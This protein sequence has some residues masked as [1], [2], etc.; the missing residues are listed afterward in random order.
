VRQ[1]LLRVGCR[2]CQAG[3]VIEAA[4]HHGRPGREYRAG[5]VG[6]AAHGNDNIE[7]AVFLSAM[8]LTASGLSPWVSIPA[9]AA[10]SVSA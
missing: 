1:R 2:R 7:T 6:M 4:V 8:T 9:E 10:S 3:R 5:F